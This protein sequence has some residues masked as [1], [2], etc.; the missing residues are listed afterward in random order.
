M[1]LINVLFVTIRKSASMLCI[2]PRKSLTLQHVLYSSQ[3][4]EE[5]SAHVLYVCV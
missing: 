4:Q 5:K 2:L 3:K 1:L